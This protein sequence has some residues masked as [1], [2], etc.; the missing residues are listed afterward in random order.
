MTAPPKFIFTCRKNPA[1]PALEKPHP[2]GK[3]PGRPSIPVQHLLSPS[4]SVASVANLARNTAGGHGLRRKGREARLVATPRI[5]WIYSR[6]TTRLI[7]RREKESNCRIRVYTLVYGI[8]GYSQF[9]RRGNRPFAAG[10]ETA[11]TGKHLHRTCH[12]PCARQAKE[13][14]GSYPTRCAGKEEKKSVSRRPGSHRGSGEAP[15]GGSKGIA[16]WDRLIKR[17]PLAA[18]CRGDLS[19]IGENRSR[20]CSQRPDEHRNRVIDALGIARHCP[21]WSKSRQADRA[22]LSSRSPES[23]CQREPREGAPSASRNAVDEPPV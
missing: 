13:K 22:D 10:E 19:L 14:R 9:N 15:L 11:C 2:L 21:A 17:R 23:L 3:C 12:P 4:R 7:I 1:S 8:E 16:A 6:A 5:E 20:T 18:T